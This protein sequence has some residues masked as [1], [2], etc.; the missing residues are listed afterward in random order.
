MLPSAAHGNPEG[1]QDQANV[2][3]EARTPRVESVEAELGA[4]WHIARR[5]DLRQASEA[6]QYCMARFVTLD[7]RQ[8]HVSSVASHFD[9]TGHERPRAHEAHI[10][11][12]DV[13][14]LRQL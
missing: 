8:R 13:P 9:F 11:G 14:E 3:P 4:A 1:D 7:R 5:I 10:A 2:E 6:R 12:E